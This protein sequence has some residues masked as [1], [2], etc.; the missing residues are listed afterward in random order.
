M[1]Q[2]GV[3]N[4][5]FQPQPQI[6]NIEQLAI[7]DPIAAYGIMLGIPR[8]PISFNASGSFS[9]FALDQNPI[10]ADLDTTIAQRTW[11]DNL[12]Y[13]L[14]LPNVFAG[15][16]FQPQY[17]ANLMAS[18]GVNVQIIVQGGPRYLVSPNYTPLENFVNMMNSRWSAGWPLFKQQSIQVFMDLVVAPPSVSPNGP[19]YN[20]TLTFNG[21]QFLDHTVD[22]ISVDVA[23]GKL[24]DMGF[25]LPSKQLECP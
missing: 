18:T 6:P 20:V 17:V 25:W 2:V 4:G 16:I 1:R 9:S 13:S 3:G 15:D 5:S 12:S 8:I 7:L 22:E 19:P 11:I 23:A 10:E 24:R 21:W 14:Q